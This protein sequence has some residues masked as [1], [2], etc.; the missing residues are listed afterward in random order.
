MHYT[1]AHRAG[2]TG[3][4]GRKRD[5]PEGFDPDDPMTWTRNLHKDGYAYRTAN[6]NGKAVQINEHRYIMSLKIGRELVGAENVH[7]LNGV[8]D[9]NRIENLELWS[10][11]HP[12]GQRVRDKVVWAKEIL[13]MYEPGALKDEGE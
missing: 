10:K 13:R 9:D 1:R 8:R 5:R 7:H 2:F 11:S 3:D 12:A 4:F 6:I